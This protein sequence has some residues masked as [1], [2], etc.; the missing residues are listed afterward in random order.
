MHEWPNREDGRPIEVLRNS[1]LPIGY[2]DLRRAVRI[3]WLSTSAAII[4][5]SL[6][7]FLIAYLN[8]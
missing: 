4:G 3:D 2:Y 5:G 1:G 6:L 8:Y 7:G